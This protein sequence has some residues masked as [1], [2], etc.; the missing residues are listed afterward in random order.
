LYIEEKSHRVDEIVYKKQR[1]VKRD[2]LD[3]AFIDYFGLIGAPSVD[4]GTVQNEKAECSHKLKFLAKK[5]DIPIVVLAQLNRRVEYRGGGDPRISD[6]R[7]TGALEQDADTTL[8][9]D[10]PALHDK[11]VD[12]L[13]K[14]NIKIGKQRNGPTG[15]IKAHYDTDTG[16]FQ[17]VGIQ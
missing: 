15:T 12:D 6:L 3:I 10:R 16:R 4:N 9:I 13:G 2:R 11:D 5:V 1:Q 7:G 17:N 8:L 14:T